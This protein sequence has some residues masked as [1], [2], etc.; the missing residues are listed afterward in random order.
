[1]VELGRLRSL[2]SQG[3]KQL[4]LMELQPSHSRECHQQLLMQAMQWCAVPNTLALRSVPRQDW[5]FK[6]HAH[7]TASLAPAFLPGSMA[8]QTGSRCQP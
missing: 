3:P 7:L 1:M 4:R 6:A 5:P 8:T 2:A